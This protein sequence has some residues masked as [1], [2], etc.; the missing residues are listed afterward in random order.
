[1]YLFSDFASVQ[2]LP[3]VATVQQLSQ[4][5]GLSPSRTYEILDE[6]EIPYLSLEKR[7]ILFKEHL[8]QGLSGKRVFTDVAKLEVIRPLPEAFSPKRLI[9]ALGIS[10]GYAYTLVR[11]PGFPA[12]FV[13]NRIIISKIGFIR[14]IKENERHIRKD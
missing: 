4:A 14:W 5:I 2:A 13:R 11:S 6:A 10:N 9:A 8:L 12:V 3:D 7:K 1:M